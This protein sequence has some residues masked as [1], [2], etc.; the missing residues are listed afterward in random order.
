ME[1]SHPARE[2]IHIDR[3]AARDKIAYPDPAAAPL[4][5]DAEAGGARLAHSH[6]H[7]PTQVSDDGFAYDLPASEE[8]NRA[9]P[10]SQP[11]WQLWGM[12]VGF[13]AA[14]AAILIFLSFQTI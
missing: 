1:S 10:R 3:G 9:T 12:M 8:D 11:G 7:T 14:G 4:G 5:T 6:A 13:M 2:R